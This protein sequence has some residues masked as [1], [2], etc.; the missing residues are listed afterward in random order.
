MNCQKTNGRVDIISTDTNKLFAMFDPIPVGNRTT[1]YRSAMVGNWYNTPL[2]DS[3]FCA[4]NI[5]SLQNQLRIGVYEASNGQYTIDKQNTD[6]LKIIM[7]G[8]FLIYSRNLPD[9]LDHQIK[10]L[11]EKVLDYC[12][13]Q[14]LGEAKG[15]MQYT[16]DAST[17]YS[18]GS[19]LIPPPMMTTKP[20]K[21]LEFK[22]W[23]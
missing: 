17:M 3:F 2:S 16:V 21:T 15:Y 1:N 8:I 11:N 12:V 7:R 23:F 6:E 5:D 20:D 4:K 9:R 13:P 10:T 18:G 19:A 22:Q 14:V